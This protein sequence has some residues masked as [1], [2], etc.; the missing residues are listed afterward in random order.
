V[1]HEGDHHGQIK[2]A[3]KGAGRPGVALE[4]NVT[5]AQRRSDALGLLAE[6]ALAADLDR[7]TSGD[8]Y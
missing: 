7:G 6:C 4:E 2:V 5:P 1:W 8:R 3:L